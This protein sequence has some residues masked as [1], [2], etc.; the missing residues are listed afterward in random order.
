MDTVDPAS[1]DPFASEFSF[2]QQTVTTVPYHEAL[3]F[4]PQHTER[5]MDAGCGS[6][7][8]SLRLAER[9]PYVV[10][11]DISPA[12]IALAKEHH[13]EQQKHNIEFLVADIENLPFAKRS[14]DFITSYTTL[15]HTNLNITLPSLRRLLKPGGRIVL[16]DIVTPRPQLHTS[17]V[18]QILRALRSTPGY[19]KRFG[20]RTGWR[21]LS[22]QTSLAWLRHTQNDKHVTPEDFQRCYSR[23]LPECNFKRS[24]GSITVFWEAPFTE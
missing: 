11:I 10:G 9:C 1:F 4:L 2:W 16:H 13:A 8:F 17:Q 20:L 22:F 19:L 18:W 7:R 3:S 24:R 23:F 6:G 12:M 14:F 21:L 15:H 5:A